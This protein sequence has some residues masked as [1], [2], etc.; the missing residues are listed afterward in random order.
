M[1]ILAYLA[2][3]E[4]YMY[5]KGIKYPYYRP[6]RPIGLLE[7]RAPTLLRQTANIW[8]QGCQRAGRILHPGSFFFSFFKIP[9]THFCYRLSRPQGHSATGKIR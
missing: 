1:G 9:G 4:H 5:G 2:T 3:N 8:R 6:W 7:F